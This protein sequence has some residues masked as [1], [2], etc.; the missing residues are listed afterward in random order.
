NKNHS[1]FANA[2]LEVQP[3]QDLRFRSSFGYRFNASSY[4]QYTPSFALSTTQ[5]NPEDDVQQSQS[6]G[7]S[8]TF[9]N[10]LSYAKTFT[11]VH[12]FE[13]LLGVSMERS[14]MGE[15]LNASNAN[16]RFPGS[17]KSAWVTNTPLISSTN[18]RVG[19][20]PW[21]EGGLSAFFG[22]LNYNYNETYM[23]TLI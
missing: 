18:T 23:A 8:Y 4:R 3:I 17:W 16:P 12:N 15:S 11:E 7:Y 13:G 14:G 2:Y 20:A 22:R 6:S 9:E 21:V 10:T 19:G 5:S 1:L